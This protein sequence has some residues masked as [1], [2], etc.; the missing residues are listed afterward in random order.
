LP[1]DYFIYGL[2][3]RSNLALPGLVSDQPAVP[4][5][6]EISF[7]SKPAFPEELKREIWYVGANLGGDGEPNLK[8]WKLGSSYFQLRYGDGTEFYVNTTGT[9]VWATWPKELTLEDTVIYF[10]G[11]VLGFV[12]RLRGTVCLHASAIAI[13]EK[14]VAIVG[15]AG[16]GKSTTAAA[17]SC[18]GYPV[19]SEDVV[20]LTSRNSTLLVEPGYPRIRLWPQS[21]DTP[22]G[23]SKALPLLTPNWDKRYLDLSANGNRFHA[24]PLPLSSVYILASR[25]AEPLAPF[26]EDLAPGSGLLTLVANTYTNYMLSSAMRSAEFAV[27]GQIVNSLPVKKVVPHQDPRRLN[28]LCELIIDDFEKS[29]RR[30]AQSV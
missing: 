19:L 15:P 5:D 24:E 9:K 14:A 10:E 8:V 16:S 28:T 4:V 12:L 11:P 29:T 1:E 2:R 17:F 23:L 26:L 18:L 30:A 6:V 7:G 25:S 21:F 3:I 27:L 20:A 22:Y 13:G